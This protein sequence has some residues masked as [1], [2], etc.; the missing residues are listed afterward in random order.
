M[1]KK[2]KSFLVVMAALLIAFTAIPAITG[3]DVEAATNGKW[4]L[5]EQNVYT[6]SAY[7]SRQNKYYKYKD[8]YEGVDSD[9]YITFKVAGGYQGPGEWSTS[10]IYHKCIKPKSSYAPGAKVTLTI[11]TI[12]KNTFNKTSSTASSS[13]KL[14]PENKSLPNDGRS[15]FIFNDM[16]DDSRHGNFITDNWKT[17]AGVGETEK[18]S[19]TMPKDPENGEKCAI[20]FLGNASAD[21]VNNAFESQYGGYQIYE[22]IY[23]Y[24][25]VPSKGVVKS[26]TNQT[27]AKAKVTVKKVSGAKNYQIKYK[28]AGSSKTITKTSTS[29]TF[30]I[31]VAKGKKVTVKA[32]VKNKI[33]W[34]NWGK[35]KS[36]TTDKK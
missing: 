26:I 24:K 15:K 7:T 19:T 9:G 17:Y 16:G 2:M 25:S 14:R 22:W 6:P 1:T 20:V 29:N 4:V 35:A 32:R 10:D 18:V 12:M 28:V 31:S 34:G 8:S 13:V 23:T 30:S 27:G 11:K 33:G 36:F 21:G 5:T 3:V